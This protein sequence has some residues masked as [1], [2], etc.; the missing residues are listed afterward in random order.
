MKANRANRA[1]AVDAAKYSVEEKA[2]T[3]SAEV[4]R[5]NSSSSAA[6]ATD[7]VTYAAAQR[8]PYSRQEVLTELA[9][10]TAATLKTSKSEQDA[11]LRSSRAKSIALEAQAT[12]QEALDAQKTASTLWQMSDDEE[13]EGLSLLRRYSQHMRS[14][15]SS[16]LSSQ[17]IACSAATLGQAWP[18]PG[19][20]IRKK[21]DVVAAVLASANPKAVVF[22]FEDGG[23]HGVGA[24]LG[25]TLMGFI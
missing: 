10:Q 24:G 12:M 11:S 20:S 2:R 6:L 19:L 18:P 5:H 21:D 25:T 23:S 16:M 8:K 13:W 17:H 14:E 15:Q 4:P 3:A 7:E 1:K 22:S 9:E